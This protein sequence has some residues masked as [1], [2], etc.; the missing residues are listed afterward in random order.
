[1]ADQV[2]M[3]PGKLGVHEWDTLVSHEFVVSQTEI[4]VISGT[5]CNPIGQVHVI[6][7]RPGDQDFEMTLFW[8]KS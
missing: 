5:V 7:D 8:P 3:I 6:H 4:S 2:T 1:M